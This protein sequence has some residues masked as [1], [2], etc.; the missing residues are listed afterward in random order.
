MQEDI[1]WV[2]VRL[3]GKR[4]TDDSEL[5][6]AERWLKHTADGFRPP[7][8]L[9]IRHAAAIQDEYLRMRAQLTVLDALASL[10]AE[11]L[12][13]TSRGLELLEGVA[14]GGESEDAAIEALV[15]HHEVTQ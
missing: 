11:G 13:P 2:P 6:E 1:L 9:S 8:E 7:M 3:R 4:V 10:R 12:Q 15:R 5:A 14:T